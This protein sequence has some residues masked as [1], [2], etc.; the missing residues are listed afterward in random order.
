METCL[1][2]N[3]DTRRKAK[4]SEAPAATTAE[5]TDRVVEISDQ[6]RMKSRETQPAMKVGITAMKDASPT[7][8]NA[9]CRESAARRIAGTM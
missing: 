9:R 5:T 2:W 4:A 8:T 6:L 3:R 1:P 7:F